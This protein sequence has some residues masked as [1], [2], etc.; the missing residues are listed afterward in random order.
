[1]TFNHRV[2]L[3]KDTYET[4]YEI[5]ET[6]YNSTGEVMFCTEGAARIGVG[7]TLEDLLETLEWAKVAVENAVRLPGTVLVDEGFEFADED[8]V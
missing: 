7:G 8:D 4:W 3:C 5:R 2:W 6:Y 1:M